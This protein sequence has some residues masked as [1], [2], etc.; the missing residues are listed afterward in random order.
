MIYNY[1]RIH[2][3]IRNKFHDNADIDLLKGLHIMLGDNHYNKLL[4]T[5]LAIYLN[6]DYSLYIVSIAYLY[7]Y[8]LDMLHPV[9]PHLE[10]IYHH[11]LSM[12]KGA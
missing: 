10:H 8:I 5:H 9:H 6:I 4:G 3:Y 2:W 7:Y 11:F 12:R 1:Y